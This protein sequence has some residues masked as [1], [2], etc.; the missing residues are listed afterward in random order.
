MAGGATCLSLGALNLTCSSSY[1]A[2]N[3]SLPVQDFVK[4]SNGTVIALNIQYRLGVFG[5]FRRY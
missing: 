4:E 3:V 2:G 1:V 5:E